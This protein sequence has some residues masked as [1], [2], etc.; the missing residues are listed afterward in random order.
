MARM[1]ICHFNFMYAPSIL[2]RIDPNRMVE[3]TRRHAVSFEQSEENHGEATYR[4][5]R[6][7]VD[8]TR[9]PD[10]RL[11]LDPGRLWLPTAQS[12]RS[13]RRVRTEQFCRV[14]CDARA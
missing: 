1:N 2:N 10:S 5:V 11:R 12:A 3:G 4:S 6:L 8:H 13:S 9:N 7:N 14:A